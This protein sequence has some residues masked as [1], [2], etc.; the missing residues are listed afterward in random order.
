M[1]ELDATTLE[2]IYPKLPEGLLS[3]VMTVVQQLFHFVSKI[4]SNRIYSDFRRNL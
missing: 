3:A 1:S 4:F 2:T